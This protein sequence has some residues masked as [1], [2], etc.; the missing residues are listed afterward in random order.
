M[1]AAIRYKLKRL[2]TL[3]LISKQLKSG[4]VKRMNTSSLKPK[5][6]S[7]LVEQWRV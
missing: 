3:T 5:H 1:N 7:Y 2:T 4:S 6:V